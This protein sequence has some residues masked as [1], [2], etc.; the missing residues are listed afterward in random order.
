MPETHVPE[1]HVF[2]PDFVGDR[3]G[4]RPLVPMVNE[5]N[6]TL[7]QVLGAWEPF[8]DD[9]HALDDVVGQVMDEVVR[10]VL[11]V[12]DEWQGRA[13]ERRQAYADLVQ[14]WSR[15]RHEMMDHKQLTT[16][17]A[18]QTVLAENMFRR[19]RE[20]PSFGS[21]FRIFP[22]SLTEA[23]IDLL[24]QHRRHPD[25]EY[26]TTEGQRKAWD[27]FDTPPWDHDLGRP[28][29]GWE[30]NR[31]TADPEAWERFDYTEERYWRRRSA[32]A[33]TAQ[34]GAPA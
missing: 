6:E 29:E 30:P 2:S 28:G 12:A 11:K 18:E 26:A 20:L 15:I 17:R 3:E 16:T 19:D 31:T 5:A 1:K 14:K 4:P 22:H 24:H 13:V 10:P 25:F 7:R 34:E 23:Q 9:P 21:G 8:S 32:P 33:T 27:D